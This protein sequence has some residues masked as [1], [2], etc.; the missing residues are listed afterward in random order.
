MVLDLLAWCLQK[1]P[2]ISSQMLV[3]KMVIYYDR[4]INITLKTNPSGSFFP[5]WSHVL[6][7]RR[8]QVV[9]LEIRDHYLPTQ[10]MHDYSGEITEKYLTLAVFDSPLKKGCFNDPYYTF[11]PPY[12]QFTFQKH[13]QP[14]L[15]FTQ[16]WVPFNDGYFSFSGSAPLSLGPPTE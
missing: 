5:I 4:K 13:L 2:N 6:S 11:K 9:F 14:N 12:K 16:K 7:A 10:T 3:K 15:S 8:L 1:V